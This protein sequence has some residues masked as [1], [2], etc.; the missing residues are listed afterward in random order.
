MKHILNLIFLTSISS[1]V[2][3][4]FN[5]FLLF[6]IEYLAVDWN[7]LTGEVPEAL[8][9]LNQLKTLILARNNFVGEVPGEFC[10]RTMDF[11]AADCDE[12][13]CLCCDLCCKPGQGCAST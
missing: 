3:I 12:V 4:L 2:L 7:A 11:L 9:N 5:S 10:D 1:P 8:G 13:T 6:T